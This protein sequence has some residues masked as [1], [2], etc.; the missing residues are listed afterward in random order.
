MSFNAKKFEE[1]HLE[2]IADEDDDIVSYRNDVTIRTSLDKMRRE[3]RM[4]ENKLYRV[5][6]IEPEFLLN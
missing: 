5:T 3:A 2:A 1:A 4:T 6:G